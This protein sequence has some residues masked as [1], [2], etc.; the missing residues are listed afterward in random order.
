MRKFRNIFIGLMAAVLTVILGGFLAIAFGEEKNGEEKNVPKIALKGKIVFVDGDATVGYSICVRNIDDSNKH[1]ITH[2]SLAEKIRAPSESYQEKVPIICALSGPRWSPDGKKIAFLGY[3]HSAP[4]SNNPV[5]DRQQAVSHTGWYCYPF[6]I[7][8]INEDG[9][10]LHRLTEFNT[11]TASVFGFKWSPDRAKILFYGVRRSNGVID[12]ASK[13]II[14]FKLDERKEIIG[15]RGG[16]QDTN[17]TALDFCWSPDGKKIVFIAAGRKRAGKIWVINTDGTG[18]QPLTRDSV[19]EVYW[20][21]D[22]KITFWRFMGGVERN[23][24]IMDSDGTNQQRI[25][26]GYNIIHNHLNRSITS[27]RPFYVFP[28]WVSPDKK[29]IIF[30]NFSLASETDRARGLQG[31]AVLYRKDIGGTDFQEIGQILPNCEFQER[32]CEYHYDL[33]L[34]Q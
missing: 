32:N 13:K 18:L 2:V 19:S 27:D 11:T 21:P 33:C 9:A 26:S 25:S 24:W 14:S 12:V 29:R 17:F 15:E 28:F 34:E 3:E 7:W 1:S 16:K 23:M 31:G 30:G 22:G 10:N 4:R 5:L 6:N 8:I 20:W